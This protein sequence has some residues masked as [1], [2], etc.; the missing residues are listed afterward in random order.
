LAVFVLGALAGATLGPDRNWSGA[1]LRP[2]PG[3]LPPAGRSFPAEVIRVFDG[4]TFQARVRLGPTGVVTTKVRLRGI[5][6]PERDARC[7][8]EAVKAEAARR[9]LVALLAQGNVRV[10]Q[11]DHDKYGRMLAL[12]ST[13]ATPDV[14]AALLRQ[15]VGRP[16]EGGHR[17]G[18]CGK[19]VRDWSGA[20][21]MR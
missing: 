3:S 9:A 1:I 14:S 15:G 12:V 8:E 18:W 4:D 16:Y 5:D 20:A 2:A 19:R 13:G 11:L 6:T 10:S 21:F 17:A 7:A